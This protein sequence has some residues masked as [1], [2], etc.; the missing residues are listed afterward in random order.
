MGQSDSDTTVGQVPPWPPVETAA[1]ASPPVAP[2]R[3]RWLRPTIISVSVLLLVVV[4]ATVGIGYYFS[5]VLLKVDHSPSYDVT[6]QS[7]NGKQIVLD[8]DDA[9][10]R[11]SVQGLEWDG[12]RAILT[13]DVRVDGDQV[14]RTIDTVVT[15]TLSAGQKVSIDT[16]V[17]GGDPG[18]RQLPFDNVTVKG[19]L[20]DLPAW[21][22]PPTAG[23]ASTT[24][25]IA[26]HGYAASRTETLR[27]LPTIAA[28]GLPTLAISYRNDVGAPASA[29]G[30][31]H[32]GDTEWRDVQAAI[33]YARDH[34]ATGVVLYAWSMGGALS[35]TALRRLPPP[36]AS[37]IKGVVMDSGNFDWTA[38]LDYQGSQRGLPGFV[39]W[40]AERII[41]WRASLSLDDLDQVPYAPQLKIPML[42]FVDRSDKT[43]PNRPAVEF[44]K[45]RPD[46]V[47]LVQTEGGGHT[48]SW[49][50]DPAGYAAAVGMFLDKVA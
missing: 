37:L 7:V 23:P 24:W 15:G 21:F 50:A 20:G 2:R 4:V 31:Y 13:K 19:E 14:E 45:T 16:R 42:V 36:E 27:A 1:P 40:T 49:N 9:T 22:V 34:G 11:P 3:R 10:E 43:V 38:I 25:V 33:G 26:V 44:A 29:D 12:G 8:R 48:G 35:M 6:V 41:E 32:L 46:L 17:Y 5:S 47:T 30:Y 18:T 39:T 28:A